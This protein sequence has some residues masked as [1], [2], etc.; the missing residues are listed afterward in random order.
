MWLVADLLILSVSRVKCTTMPTT[1][2]DDDHGLGLCSASTPEL[3]TIDPSLGGARGMRQ[4]SG[5][6]PMSG[7]ESLKV[8]ASDELGDLTVTDAG[9]KLGNWFMVS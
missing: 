9:A 7:R 5:V 4:K 1:R 6:C 3:Y 2:Y 8:D